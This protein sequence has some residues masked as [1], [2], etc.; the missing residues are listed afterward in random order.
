MIRAILDGRKG[1]TRRIVKPQPPAGVRSAG[2]I[3]SQAE[4]NG[5][6]G[7]L[8]AEDLMD[9]GF[10]GDWF[11]CPFGVP[12]DRLWV[13]ETWVPALA[14]GAFYRATHEKLLRDDGWRGKWKPSI[15]MPRAASRITLTITDIRCEPLQAISET[16]AIA[17]GVYRSGKRWE[18]E[19]IV[20][21]PFSAADAYKSLWNYIHGRDAWDQNPW[22][23]VVCFTAEKKR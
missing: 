13:K 18:I 15:F 22:V 8:D 20:A 12:G 5:Q 10:I 2:V 17:E 4:S 21:T 23:W 3:H 9:A 1:Q 14:V 16:D 11:R 7:W 19:G 6:W